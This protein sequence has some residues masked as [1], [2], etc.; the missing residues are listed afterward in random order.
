MAAALYSNKAIKS[1]DME[2]LR[3]FLDIFEEEAQRKIIHRGAH[4]EWRRVKDDK[5]I[6]LGF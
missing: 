4:I 5:Y 6:S 1:S 3:N 2:E